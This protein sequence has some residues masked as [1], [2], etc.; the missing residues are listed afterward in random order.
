MFKILRKLLLNSFLQLILVIVLTS[1]FYNN[2]SIDVI[3]FLLTISTCLRELLVFVLPFLL[4][5]FVAVALSNIQQQGMIFVISLMLTVLVSNFCNILVSGIIGFF[6][7]SDMQACETSTNF[8]EI[9]P[10]FYFSLPKILPTTY[11]LIAGIIIGFYNSLKPNEYIT[12]SINFIHDCVMKFMKKFF[13]PLL[14]IFVGGFMLKLFAEGRMTGFIEHNAL[15]CV[16][17]CGILWCYLGIWLLI[18]SSFRFSRAITIL[19]NALPA[20]IT[21]F[22]TMSSA[23]ALPMSLDAARKNTH[24]KTL[25]D[26]VM[27][28][29]LNFHMV[30][31]TIIVPIMAMIVMLAFNKPLPN[32]YNFLMFA[33]FFVLN[34][35][36]GGGV[37]SGTIMVTLPVLR[38]YLGF[39]DSM[40]AF[41]IAFY[42]IFDPV[43]TSGNVAA[44][45]FF[46]VIFQ[47][48]M[49]TIKKTISKNIQ[50]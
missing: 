25:S 16:L 9:F 24:D 5:S 26:A 40:I 50:T 42:G 27:P 34:K 7:L 38:D 43:A 45:N 28:L 44:N 35:F 39:D 20:I 48:I 4:F 41:I 19:K 36:A 18:A 6:L 23:S 31:D 2:L 17:I 22:S 46:V 32:V 11:S 47:K 37:P 1:L 13:I 30:G 29:T 33:I 49:R 8:S 14:P 3:R 10:L 12:W 15:I 21:A